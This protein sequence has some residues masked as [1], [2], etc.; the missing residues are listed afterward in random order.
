VR[1]PVEQGFSTTGL[2][3]RVRR[4]RRNDGTTT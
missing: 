3:E 4:L 1:M 2:I